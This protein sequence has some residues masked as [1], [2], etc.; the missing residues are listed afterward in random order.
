[1]FST[2]ANGTLCVF[3]RKSMQS[4][5][6]CIGNAKQISVECVVKCDQDRY[7]AEAE[8]WSNPLSLPLEESGKPAKCMVFVGRDQLWC[9][10]GNSIIVVD[11]IKMVVLKSILVFENKMW[12]IKT[13]VSNG[14][15]VWAIGR[16]LSCVM[17]W[18]AKT[19]D[20]LHIFNCNPTAENIIHNA[21][22][23]DELSIPQEI[24]PNAGEKN[25]GAPKQDTKMDHNSHTSNTTGGFTVVN[26]PKQISNAPFSQTATWRTLRGITPRRRAATATTDRDGRNILA[27]MRDLI[28]RRQRGSP[29]ATSLVIVGGTLWVARNIGDI[30]VVD[31]QGGENHGRVLA[32]L[33]TED[34]EKFGDL[35]HQTLVDV[36]GEYVVGSQWLVPEVHAPIFN[37][38]GGNLIFPE[39][40]EEQLMGTHQA[41]TIWS[42]W[43][44]EKINQFSRRRSMQ[45]MQETDSVAGL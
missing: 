23:I 44:H 10:C 26:D 38:P 40:S 15:R 21:K 16:Q 13:L 14:D 29:R 12:F 24:P 19:F 22:L 7:R 25:L 30:L 37:P 20:L 35:S 33:A 45:L 3:V 27:V 1:M 2:L 42:A 31:I 32:R 5:Q 18:D 41:I 28:H 17:E 4:E 43:N 34:G 39:N 8:D 36:A 6:D 11:I 9:G